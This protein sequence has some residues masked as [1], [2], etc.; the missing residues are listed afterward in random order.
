MCIR[1]RRPGDCLILNNSRVLPARLLGHRLP[2]G[3]ACE[4]LLLIDRGDNVWA[5]S[6]T[7]LEQQKKQQQ[8]AGV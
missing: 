3:G 1:D 8:V 2:G 6:Y 4:I 7:H 5:V